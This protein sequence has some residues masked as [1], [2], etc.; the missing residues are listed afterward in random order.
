MQPVMIGANSNIQDSAVTHSKSGATVT[1]GGHSSIAHRS[2]VHGPCEIGNQVF[3]GF[4]SV[5]LDYRVGDGCVVRHSMVADGRD[6]LA[7]F[8]T[9]S[10]ERIDSRTDLVSMPRVSISAGE[11]SE[12]MARTNVDLVRD[13]KS[14]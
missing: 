13:Y 12:G 14:L 10:T 8:Y 5:P 3:I 11:S 6:L 4:N 9:P 1:I 2:I 7:G